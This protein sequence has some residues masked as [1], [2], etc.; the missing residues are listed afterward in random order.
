MVRL[1]CVTLGFFRRFSLTISNLEQIRV[2]LCP[3][4]TAQSLIHGLVAKLPYLTT[5]SPSAPNASPNS[6]NS[7]WANPSNI[8]STSF[9]TTTKRSSSRNPLQIQNGRTSRRKSSMR[10]R[11]TRVRRGKAQDMRYTTFNTSWR[12]E[13]AHG[14]ASHLFEKEECFGTKEDLGTRLSSFRGRPMR[15]LWFSYVHISSRLSTQ[16]LGR[17]I[18]SSPG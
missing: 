9:Q 2:C 12:V 10:S 13:R 17:L 8:S 4:S 11:A 15:E 18:P 3:K 14:T 16:R 7:N 1:L 5:E 6:T